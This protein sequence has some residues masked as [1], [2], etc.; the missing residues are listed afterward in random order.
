MNSGDWIQV[1]GLMFLVILA[2]AICWI[3]LH[4]NWYYAL[5]ITVLSGTTVWWL[6]RQIPW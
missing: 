2:I 4:L 5:P 1:G 6:H 3:W